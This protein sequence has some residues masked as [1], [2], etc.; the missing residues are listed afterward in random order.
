MSAAKTLQTQLSEKESQVEVLITDLQSDIG[1]SDKSDIGKSDK[2]DIGKSD[3]SDIEKSDKFDK[4]DKSN[5]SDI[6]KCANI[7]CTNLTNL[8]ISELQILKNKITDL[9]NIKINQSNKY[10]SSDILKY[11]ILPFSTEIGNYK[12]TNNLANCLQ[13]LD[14]QSVHP[15]DYEYYKIDQYDSKTES[16]KYFCAQKILDYIDDIWIS[17]K[18]QHKI[19]YIDVIEI[20]FSYK[21]ELYKNIKNNYTFYNIFKLRISKNNSY[22]LLKANIY[23]L[24]KYHLYNLYELYFDKIDESSDIQL[25]QYLDIGYIEILYIDIQISDN[26]N[27][28]SDICLNSK[29][30]NNWNLTNVH[31]NKELY[32]CSFYVFYN[33]FY[34]NLKFQKYIYSYLEK[35]NNESV[36]NFNTLTVYDKEYLVESL[37]TDLVI[38]RLTK[39]EY[40]KTDTYNIKFTLKEIIQLKYYKYIID[41]INASYVLVNLIINNISL[42]MYNKVKNLL[43]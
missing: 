9:L 29:I 25:N 43:F 18:T 10:I 2:S 4:S 36:L 39:D 19:L 37:E 20:Y 23:E 1:K 26:E 17:Y 8:S 31:K 32:N 7:D 27:K 3:K 35:Y 15:E 12:A 38:F 33:Y 40:T 6:G 30:S 21:P 11:N 5:K 14:T 22:N 24:Y 16:L 13:I 41:A 28:V 42:E 34:T